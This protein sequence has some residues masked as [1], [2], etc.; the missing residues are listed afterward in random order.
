MV[1]TRLWSKVTGMIPGMTTKL[2]I[3]LPDEYVAAAKQ[4]VAD[5]RAT[6]VS[7]YIA[8]A[9]ARRCADDDLVDMLAEMKAEHGHPSDADYT[10]AEQALGLR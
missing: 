8:E 2:A 3:T 10:W 1:I 5:G 7:A 9:L 6:S 4:A